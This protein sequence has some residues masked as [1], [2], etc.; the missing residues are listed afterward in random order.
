MDG[1]VVLFAAAR[2]VHNWELITDEVVLD[3]VRS[4]FIVVL[5]NKTHNLCLTQRLS[6]DISGGGAFALGINSGSDLEQN[7]RK[8]ICLSHKLREKEC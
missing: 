3:F 2:L 6:T 5:G 1:L 8:E 7:L 4:K